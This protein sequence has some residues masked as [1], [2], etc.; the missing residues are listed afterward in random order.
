MTSVPCH[1]YALPPVC[2]VYT[3]LHTFPCPARSCVSLGKLWS[4]SV[5]VSLHGV[6][7]M[8]WV[9][10]RPLLRGPSR[11]DLLKETC[12]LLRNPDVYTFGP[13]WS[14]RLLGTTGQPW[15]YSEFQASLSY[16]TLPYLGAPASEWVEA[17]D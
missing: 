4:Y 2:R 1:L 11:S 3:N 10:G 14:E 9:L 16:V 7:C 15:L 5:P 12:G 17:T 6:G 13:Q 8:N